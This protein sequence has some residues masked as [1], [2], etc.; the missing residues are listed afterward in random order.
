MILIETRNRGKEKDSLRYLKDIKKSLT[1]YL[2]SNYY[3]LSINYL[4]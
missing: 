3:I 4:Y 1:S 2:K